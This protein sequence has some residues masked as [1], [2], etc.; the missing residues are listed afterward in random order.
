ME[1]TS[2]EACWVELPR[3]DRACGQVLLDQ[4]RRQY[5]DSLNLR[6]LA[7]APAPG[8]HDRQV[9]A[10]GVRI[11]LPPDCPELNPVERLWQDLKR[12]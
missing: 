12:R 8:A 6:V 1:P 2:G 5:V 7:N 10:H 9:P 11:D 4:F 3:L